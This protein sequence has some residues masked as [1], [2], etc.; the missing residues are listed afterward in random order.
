SGSRN[1]GS[2]STLSALWYESGNFNGTANHSHTITWSAASS[3]NLPPY[4]TTIFAKRKAS[5]STSLGSEESPVPDAPTAQAA[6][7]T[8]TTS[9]TWNFTDNSSDEQGF[10][11]YDTLDALKVTCASPN[12][13]SCLESTL[14]ENTQYT[15][16]FT[17]YNVHGD[18]EF[19]A[20]A[21]AYTLISTP[22]IV[23][24]SSTVDTVDLTAS[25]VANIL[26]GS[27]GYYFDCT[28]A[29]GDSGIN[30]WITTDTDISTGLDN[31]TGY[32]YQ[33]KARNGDAV[34]TGYSATQEVWTKAVAP[35]LS[36]S[37]FTDTTIMLGVT[38]VN[39]LAQG[40]SG[41]YFECVSGSCSEGID[42]WVAT[43]TDTSINLIPNTEYTFKAKARNYDS[44]E[45]AYSGEVSKYTKATQPAMSSITSVSESGMTVIINP[46]SNPSSTLYVV[47]EVNTSKYITLTGTLDVA[48]VWL[49][50]AQLG[51]ASG[52]AVT[53]LD[54]NTEYTFRVK[55]KNSDAVETGYSAP[56]S[57]YT[58]LTA[59][60]SVTL[61]PDTDTD[62]T[63]DWRL[64]TTESGYDGIKVYDESNTLVKTCIVA[65]GTMCQESGLTPNTLYTRKLTIYSTH[66]ESGYS[67][68]LSVRTHAQDISITSSSAVNDYEVSLTIDLGDNPAGTNIQIYEDNLSKYYDDTLGVL[69]VG[70]SQFIPSQNTITISGLSPN[71][72]YTFKVRAIDE[73]SNPTTWSATN[74]VRTH[75]EIPNIVTTTPTSTTAGSITI[76]MG[77]NPAGTRISIFETGTEKYLSS[78]TN[79]LEDSKDVFVLV[80]DTITVNSLLP[81]T[82]YSFKVK[83]YNEADVVTEF[84]DEVTLTTLIQSPTVSTTN[85][86]SSTADIVISD[87]SNITEGNSGAYVEDIAI[88]NQ[89]LNQTVTGLNPNSVNTFRVMARNQNSIETSYVS[90]SSVTTLANTPVI[91]TVT[92]L[93]STTARVFLS[94]NGNPSTTQIAIRDRV[95]GLYVNTNGTLQTSPVWQTYTQ[96]GG[97]S[98]KYITGI[99]TVRQLGFEAKARN[100]DSIETGF[101]DAVYIGTGAVIVNAPEDIS[102]ILKEDTDLDVTVTGLLGVQDIQI[103]KDDYLLLDLSV[104]FEEDRD[105]SDVVVD[106][107]FVNGKAVVKMNEDHGVTE[108]FTMYVVMKD[109]NAF[110]ICPQATTLDEVSSNCVEGV[111]V[112]D[113]FPQEVDVEGDTVTI[114]Q[115]KIDGVYYWIADGLT[116]TGCM[117]EMI[118][119]EETIIIDEEEI[120]II[121]EEDNISSDSILNTIVGKA[122]G[123]AEEAVL[124]SSEVLDNTIIGTLNEEQLTNVVNTTTTATITIGVATTGLS[125]TFY[126]LLHFINGLLNALGFRRKKIPFGYVYDSKSKNPIR[127]AVVRIFK[128]GKLLE[129][130]VTDSNGIFVSKLDS[131]KYTIKVKKNGYE[132]PSSLVKGKDD[133]PLKHIYKGGVLKKSD[134][135]EI[136]VSIPLDPKELKDWRRVL[137]ILKSVL[138][139]SFSI[140]NLVL[141]G[142]GVSML[143]YTYYKYQDAFNLYIVLLYIPALYFLSTSLFNRKSKYGQLVDPNGRPITN[144]EILLVENEFENV[145]D[146]RVTDKK[147]KFRFVC[148][149]GKYSLTMGKDVL[150]E[151]IVIK[152][153]GKLFAKRVVVE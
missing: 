52:I 30:A 137:V 15:R 61:T 76:D 96:W 140:F 145:V 45:T 33:V 1:T 54:S 11:V 71:T 87:L 22:N 9:I 97:S 151:N 38:G 121:D 141:F 16:K 123:I 86:T 139:V 3:S 24:Y 59:P 122:I 99:D 62:T 31:N 149:K 2:V 57:Q 55:A 81:N 64:I 94:L 68:T 115:A 19:S 146:K 29:S 65:N 120:I 6:T 58:V 37:D 10:K 98:G 53:G 50:Y 18:S 12:I 118:D 73:E 20:T 126:L 113:D 100:R 56:L 129:T 90:S 42:T 114:S 72:V 107:D 133:Y 88:W 46:Y 101:S 7:P 44:V 117:G 27:S 135:L 49:T 143:I 34:E 124:S 152:K 112:S 8:S 132:F 4:L 119:P 89:S 77:D 148:K 109:S 106:A 84:S 150:V 47:E 131:G 147:G 82:S 95:S 105:W 70:E 108:P 93:S 51:G 32:T 111:L 127:N 142:F 17:A 80:G 40:S 75:A 130:T 128:G 43:D 14:S 60:T 13:S 116:G 26:S 138:S 125:Q 28:E 103:T 136:T 83:A 85:I 25:T 144:K 21:T 134:N 66:S 48:P 78:T 153:D 41:I 104:S 67:N 74:N 5:Q 35:N 69:V 91:S 36:V 92:K 110:R 39:N 63:I 79:T 102:L 23:G